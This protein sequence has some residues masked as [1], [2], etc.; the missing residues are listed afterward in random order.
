MSYIKLFR[1][2]SQ[3]QL[4]VEKETE[5]LVPER[6]LSVLFL[7]GRGDVLTSGR[8]CGSA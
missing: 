7:L 3:V 5:S 8:G 6:E 1:E 2:R 4:V